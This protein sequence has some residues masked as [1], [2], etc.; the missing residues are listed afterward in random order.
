[1]QAC[2]TSHGLSALRPELDTTTLEAMIEDLFRIISLVD[3]AG[4]GDVDELLEGCKA[5]AAF[6]EATRLAFVPAL[7]AGTKIGSGSSAVVR[8]A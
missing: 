3:F 1:L 2:Q 5:Y 7:K 4:E 8:N 6:R